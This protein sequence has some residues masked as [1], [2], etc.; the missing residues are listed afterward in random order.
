MSKTY[1]TACAVLMTSILGQ[2]AT[3]AA[4]TIDEGVKLYQAHNYAGALSVWRPLAAQSDPNALFNLG[5]AYRLGRGVKVDPVQAAKY[6]E[7][8]AKLGHVAAQGNL[9]TLLYFGAPPI[10]D[11]RRAIELYHVAARN[12]DAR[13]Q[14]MLGVLYFNGDDVGKDWPKAYAYTSLAKDAGLPEATETS[15]RLTQFL[16]PED[17]QQGQSIKATL[18]SASQ[19]LPG[20]LPPVSAK[21][22][23]IMVIARTAKPA[24]A[25]TNASAS[26]KAPTGAAQPPVATPAVVPA[27]IALNTVKP[28]GDGSPTVMSGN[29]TVTELASGSTTPVPALPPAPTI[30]TPAVPTP[31]MDTAPVPHTTTLPATTKTRG[32]AIIN[33]SGGNWHV[34]LGAYASQAAA[35]A[36]WKN[37]HSK[38]VASVGATEPAYVTAGTVTKLQVGSFSSHD[39]AAKAC[40]QMKA[41]GLNC[42]PVKS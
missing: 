18:V 21:P 38:A 10:K 13:A 39:A 42:F 6:Y 20:T 3:V 8:A 14:Y 7:Q 29:S 16:K 28:S 19:A 33:T 17:V 34:Q 31:H 1:T 27:T 9:A 15:N 5:Q 4:G 41:Q 22:A 36:Q 24:V 40:G 23:P 25:W 26:S 37:Q 35:E 30:M 11:N 12:G 2:H 32:G